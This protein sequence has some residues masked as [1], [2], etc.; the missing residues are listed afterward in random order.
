MISRSYGIDGSQQKICDFP[1]A[2]L[3]NPEGMIMIYCFHL[4]YSDVNGWDINEPNGI[5]RFVEDDLVCF[6]GDML[7]FFW[8]LLKQIQVLLEIDGKIVALWM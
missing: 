7:C 3:K 1:M 8:R 4:G 5:P 6:L 2:M